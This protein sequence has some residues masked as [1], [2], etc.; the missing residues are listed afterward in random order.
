ML[1]GFFYL[2]SFTT[3]VEFNNIMVLFLNLYIVTAQPS[4]FTSLLSLQLVYLNIIYY[5][6]YSKL[7][8]TNLISTVDIYNYFFNKKSEI[9]NY[10][11][12]RFYLLSFY[13]N[14][15]LTV[16]LFIVT[17]LINIS[18]VLSLD[19]IVLYEIL[20]FNPM[21]IL[22]KIGTYFKNINLWGGS[23]P[24]PG[25]P[26][27]FN[28]DEILSGS[29]L[30]GNNGDENSDDYKLPRVEACLF[31]GNEGKSIYNTMDSISNSPSSDHESSDFDSMI[32]IRRR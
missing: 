5:F 17:I 15:Y 6:N 16:I 14:R 22:T 1:F 32:T 31:K 13:L 8:M 24:N 11:S 26:S 10:F 2:L 29:T 12:I 28:G 18:V 27:P 4:Q 30:E 19:S 20:N 3:G 7:I 23:A 25:S 9:I 21:E